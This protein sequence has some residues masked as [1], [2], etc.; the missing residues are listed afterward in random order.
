MGAS[1]SGCRAAS[2]CRVLGP[3]LSAASWCCFLGAVAHGHWGWRL[4]RALFVPEYLQN[5]TL[6]ISWA[7]PVMRH[8]TRWI[9]QKWLVVVSSSIAGEFQSHSQGLSTVAGEVGGTAL[10]NLTQPP[11][12]SSWVARQAAAAPVVARATNQQPGHHNIA[13]QGQSNA[14]LAS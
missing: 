11:P 2:W 12:R 14:A 7:F 9:D 8:L 1:C 6:G 5:G 4:H 3:L 10:T 13:N